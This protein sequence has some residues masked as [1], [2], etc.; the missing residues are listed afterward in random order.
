M[1]L[2][3]PWEDAKPSRKVKT[4]SVDRRDREFRQEAALLGPGLN[5][6]GSFTCKAKGLDHMISK[7]SFG[8]TQVKSTG[9]LQHPLPGLEHLGH[10]PAFLFLPGSNHE[11][12]ATVSTSRGTEL[13]APK[14]SFWRSSSKIQGATAFAR[15][16]RSAPQLR[17]GMS[18]PEARIRSD[19]TTGASGS[20][21][22]LIGPSARRR[23]GLW[24]NSAGSCG[25]RRRRWKTRA[26]A[27]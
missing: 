5:D 3:S 4:K 27:E 13:G 23:R 18:S 24:G 9:V 16:G 10:L 2:I 11:E 6:L 26:K 25:W 20:G 7:G 19:S 14:G 1:L 17:A 22:A 21:G 12:G 8:R 15:S